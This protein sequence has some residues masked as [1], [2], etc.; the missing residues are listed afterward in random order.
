[1][2]NPNCI[3]TATGTV[4][5][6]RQLLRHRACNINHQPACCLRPPVSS[7]TFLGTD[8]AQQQ[9]VCNRGEVCKQILLCPQPHTGKQ[10]L[11]GGHR[12]GTGLVPTLANLHSTVSSVAGG[13]GHD[14]GVLSSSLL[15]QLAAPMIRDAPSMRQIGEL[16]NTAAVDIHAETQSCQGRQDQNRRT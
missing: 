4:R 5:Q 6:R 8:E 14:I 3:H 15:L 2:S 11:R 1:M 10:P 16:W 9:R 13:L 7:F 12:G